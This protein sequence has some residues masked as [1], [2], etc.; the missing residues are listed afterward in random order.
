[1]FDSVECFRKVDRADVQRYTPLA[2]TLLQHPVHHEVIVTS[3]IGSKPRLVGRLYSVQAGC[4]SSIKYRCEQLV[5]YWQTTNWPVISCILS[6][7]FFVNYL[8]SY[9]RQL[10][11]VKSSCCA[12][13]LKII[14]IFFFRLVTAVFELFGSY[15]IAVSRFPFFLVVQ[16]RPGSRQL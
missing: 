9:F 1:M 12:I 10:F 15:S 6:V 7:T 5:H 3:V 14:L 8:Y 4:E 11:G 2:T 13:S 16:W